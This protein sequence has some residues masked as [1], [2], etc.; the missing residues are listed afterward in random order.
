MVA[1]IMIVALLFAVPARAQDNSLQ[2]KLNR[3]K[4]DLSEVPED[5]NKLSVR[6]SSR[7][8]S[9]V[10]ASI[11]RRP[12]L[13]AVPRPP[14]W[15]VSSIPTRRARKLSRTRHPGPSRSSYPS[16]FNAP[17]TVSWAAECTGP[18]SE[19]PCGPGRSQPGAEVVPGIVEPEVPITRG[20]SVVITIVTTLFPPKNG[21][22]PFC[23][24]R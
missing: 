4:R 20:W 3:L 24:R 22:N 5:P 7:T 10:S 11:G 18:T 23:L 21:R 9:P 2:D 12:A 15:L 17:L 19:D 13:R 16:S 8:R 14:W 6:A 1:L